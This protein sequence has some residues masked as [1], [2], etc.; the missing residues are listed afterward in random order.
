[1]SLPRFGEVIHSGAYEQDAYQRGARG[2]A[3]T[4][5]AG[6][7]HRRTPCRLGVRLPR[8]FTKA[9]PVAE[10]SD[11]MRHL[12]AYTHE[13]SSFAGKSLATKSTQLGPPFNLP[14]PA[15]VSYVPQK[16]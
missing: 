1:M 15:H 7:S 6:G 11:A 8:S 2:A 12:E 13:G 9:Y 16:A 14:S 4:A 10:V 5:D 3:V